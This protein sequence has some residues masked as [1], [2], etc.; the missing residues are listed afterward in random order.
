MGSTNR[1]KRLRAEPTLPANPHPVSIE[2]R[3][4][5]RKLL[6]SGLFVSGVLCHTSSSS[7]SPLLASAT[8]AMYDYIAQNVT[9]GLLRNHSCLENIRP[10]LV[11]NKLAVRSLSCYSFS[12]DRKLNAKLSSQSWGKALPIKTKCKPSFAEALCHKR[13]F[14]GTSHLS[15]PA[16]R[17]QEIC[18]ASH[19]HSTTNAACSL[20][21]AGSLWYIR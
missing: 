15:V 14:L 6:R 12:F 5:E 11:Q 3:R 9:V 13:S 16:P 2:Q 10:N 19:R 1:R 4:L 18:M 8:T 17:L 7:P 21:V 20:L